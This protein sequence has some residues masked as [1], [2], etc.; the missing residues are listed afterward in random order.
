[1]RTAAALLV[2]AGLVVSLAACSAPSTESASDCAATPSGSVSDGVKVTGE[3]GSKPTISF[4]SPT[5][6]KETERTVVIAGEGDAAEQGSTVN[7]NFTMLNG[8]TG[9]EL[10]TTEYGAEAATALPI[11]ATQFLPGIVKTLECSTAGSRVVGVITAEDGF[12]ETGSDLGVEPGEDLVFVVDVVSI[13]PPADP[14][15]PKADGEDQPATDGFP[16]VVLDADGAPT[17]TIPDTAPPV[18]LQLAVLKQGDGEVVQPGSDVV[19]HYTGINWNT[20]VVFDSSWERGTPATF[21]TAGVIAG[22]TRALEGQNVGSQ[23]IVIIPPDLGYGPQGGRAPDISA[24]DT[25]VFVIDI[26]GIG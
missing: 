24:T 17:V 23:V 3:F 5:A 12:G 20:K 14:P 15:L 10:T 1:M 26:L 8:T 21:N 2:T 22:F 9:A 16:V 6:V 19:V 13:D 11:D 18:E 4:T 7:V 25:L